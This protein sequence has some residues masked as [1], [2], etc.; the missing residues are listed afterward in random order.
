ML[1]N[2]DERMRMNQW[3]PSGRFGLWFSKFLPGRLVAKATTKSQIDERSPNPSAWSIL[4]WCF[5][6]W[7][8]SWN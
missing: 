1:K 3:V 6:Y 4:Y 2:S 7:P 5:C 8:I